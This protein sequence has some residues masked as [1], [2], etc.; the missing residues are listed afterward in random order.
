MSPESLASLAQ[1][2]FILIVPLVLVGGGLFT[3][4]AIGA[5][6]D[7]LENPGELKGRIESAF[8][9][10]PKAPKV[11]GPDHYYRPYWKAE[12]AKRAAAAAPKNTP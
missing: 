6:F 4:F 9:R 8:K 10:P 5:L 11:P 7:A 3:L 2:A 12:P 1:F